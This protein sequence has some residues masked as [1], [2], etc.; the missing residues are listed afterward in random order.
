MSFYDVFITI[1]LFK[2]TSN[3]STS[4]RIRFQ[5]IWMRISYLTIFLCS[6]HCIFS[7]TYVFLSFHT[8]TST[9]ILLFFSNSSQFSYVLAA[10]VT[11][12]I[13]NYIISLPNSIRLSLCLCVIIFI[14]V[15]FFLENSLVISYTIFAL[16]NLHKQIS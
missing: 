6:C 3:S 13:I 14:I 2:L 8:F 5:L 9:N 10:F 1:I 11:A 16:F 7:R 12:I 15:L 4:I